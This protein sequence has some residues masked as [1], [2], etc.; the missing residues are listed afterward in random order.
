MENEN[1][2][3]RWAW[4]AL[5]GL[6]AVIIIA[7]IVMAM[8][9]SSPEPAKEVAKTVN[10]VEE[11]KNEETTQEPAK[12]ENTTENDTK[13][14]AEP[15]TTTPNTESTPSAESSNAGSVATT[16]S[17]IPKTGPEDTI[18]PIVALAICSSLFAYNV[19]LFKK[20]A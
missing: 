7:G 18:L 12:D 17:N 16:E 6:V 8:S 14:E 13:T 10:T 11:P 4:G 15:Q 9:L 5:I 1:K 3:R 19:V 2:Y 20:N